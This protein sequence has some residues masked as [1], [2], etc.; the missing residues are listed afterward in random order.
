MSLFSFVAA[1]PFSLRPALLFKVNLIDV[2]FDLPSPSLS[3]LF[4]QN[5]LMMGFCPSL[6]S[7][8][9]YFAP[10]VPD[11][12]PLFSSSLTSLMTMPRSTA[13]HMS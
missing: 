10:Q 4:F 2:R 11:L 1:H 9:C 12:P 13:L 5:D 8:A 7:H 3:I 6:R